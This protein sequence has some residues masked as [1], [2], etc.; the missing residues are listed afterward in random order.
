[1]DPQRVRLV[2]RALERLQLMQQEG[3]V[4]MMPETM[5]SR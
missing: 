2:I 1:L 5:I 3:V 4:L